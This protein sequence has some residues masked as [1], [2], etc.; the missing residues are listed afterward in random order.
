MITVVSVLPKRLN[1]RIIC[2]AVSVFS[3]GGMG[4]VMFDE[5]RAILILYEDKASVVSSVNLPENATL[6][7]SMRVSI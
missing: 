5:S 4:S 3:C 1:P 7:F 6:L 2:T